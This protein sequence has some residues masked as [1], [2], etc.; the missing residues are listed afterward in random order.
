MDNLSLERWRSLDASSALIAL[1]DYAKADPTYVP[2][3]SATSSRWHVSCAGHD[4]ELLLTGP[5]F[6]DTRCQVGGGG[7]IDLVMHLHS[8][9]FR[10][11]TAL[12]KRIGL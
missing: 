3:A 4:F 2:V 11:A 8:C 10:E 1:A 9:S 12:L 6:W 7:A 5:K